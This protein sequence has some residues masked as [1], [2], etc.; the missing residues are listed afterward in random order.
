M[1]QAGL[2]LL[3]FPCARIDYRCAT[4]HLA[5]HQTNY[6]CT[7]PHYSTSTPY[8]V[9]GASLSSHSPGL[10]IAVASLTVPFG[11]AV[12]PRLPPL[13]QSHHPRWWPISAAGHSTWHCWLT[14]LKTLS[15]LD[16]RVLVCISPLRLCFLNNHS[17][18]AS[19]FVQF[20]NVGYI[21]WQEVSSHL[22]LHSSVECFCLQRIL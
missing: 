4:P 1:A 21:R 13:L 12:P 18:A 17:L 2:K 5:L 19:P 6:I 10:E 9:P 14:L 8:L 3:L 11:W 22:I 20:L 15:L 16:L 7:E